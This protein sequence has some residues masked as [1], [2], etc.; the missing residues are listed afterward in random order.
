MRMNMTNDRILTSA[1]LQ[2]TFNFKAIFNQQK[3]LHGLTQQQLAE[4]I[5]ITTDGISKY[6]T[7]KRAMGDDFIYRI[8]S[9][10]NVSPLEIKPD[11]DLDG[12]VIREEL[13]QLDKHQKSLVLQFIQSIK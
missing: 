2:A 7:G 9:V 8:A 4:K 5:G 12:Y 1:D 11:F 3:E 6:M 10:L 13:K